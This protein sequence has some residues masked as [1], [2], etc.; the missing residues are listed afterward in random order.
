MINSRFDGFLNKIMKIIL[1]SLMVAISLYVYQNYLIIGSKEK[2]DLI[3]AVLSKRSN[4]Q[5]REV[6]RKTWASSTSLKTLLKIK[7]FFII[8]NR[9]CDIPNNYRIEPRT[10]QQANQIKSDVLTGNEEQIHVNK[11]LIAANNK[12]NQKFSIGFSF[13]V[14]NL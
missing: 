8:G 1:S 14:Y 12:Y 13:K 11:A 3:I 10:C 5:Q 2:L 7:T 4:F 6:I 9:D